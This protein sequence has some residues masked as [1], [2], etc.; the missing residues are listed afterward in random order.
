MT[1]FEFWKKKLATE[2]ERERERDVDGHSEGVGEDL[3]A[4]C[5]AGYH[6]SA[7]VVLRPKAFKKKKFFD[8]WLE[9]LLR[10]V[11]YG[12]NYYECGGK[13][14]EGTLC[15]VCIDRIFIFGA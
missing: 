4:C 12:T 2:R 3:K 13:G 15:F 1:H 7:V 6:F 8:R 9:M 10:P 14:E 5:Y 11:M